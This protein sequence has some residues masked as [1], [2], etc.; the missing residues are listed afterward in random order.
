MQKQK[1]RYRREIAIREIDKPSVDDLDNEI[2]WICQ[3]LGLSEREDDLAADI[4]KELLHATK[5]REG[6]STKE[7][8]EKKHVTQGAVVYHLN[9]FMSSGVVIKQGRRYFLRSSSLDETIEEL[10]QDL[11]RRM[12]KMREL[13]KEIDEKLRTEGY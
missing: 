8:K 3:C 5:E 11:L 2:E 9:I 1:Q 13:A 6:I 10:E 4:F 7:I 12:R